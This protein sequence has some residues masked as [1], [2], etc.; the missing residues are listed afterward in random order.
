M[1]IFLEA[2]YPIDTKQIHSS[3][4]MTLED[5][6]ECMFEM[7]GADQTESSEETTKAVLS[8][9][10]KSQR[11][12]SD[13]T[14]HGTVEPGRMGR[15]CGFL[16]SIILLHQCVFA[17]WN[18][19]RSFLSCWSQGLTFR[20]DLTSDSARRVGDK[21]RKMSPTTD[22]LWCIKRWTLVLQQEFII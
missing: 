7:Q 2:I 14:S 1:H 17:I 18:K 3:S 5:W 10:G 6:P 21:M 11:F 4:T 8:C 19:Q 16:I 15:A 9:W 20:S 13:L 22:C 12:R